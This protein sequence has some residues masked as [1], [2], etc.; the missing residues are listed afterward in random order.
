MLFRS[1]DVHGKTLTLQQAAN[2]LRQQDRD[3][4]E[5]VYFKISNRRLL[6]REKLDEL[7]NELLQ[8]RDRIAKNAGFENYRDYKFVELDR[9]DYTPADCSDFHNS[10]QQEIV[11]IVN[12]ML[13]KRKEELKVDA[14][15][16]WDLE[17]DPSGK[18]ELKPFK[19]GHELT[20]KTIE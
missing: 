5:E 12:N 13:K 9:F 3:L 17:V 8:Y 4:R 2:Y 14:L 7:F 6:D 18:P 15:Y 10:V 1:V 19:T 16:P 20:K 11:P